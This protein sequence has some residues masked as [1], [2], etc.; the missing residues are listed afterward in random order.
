[1]PLLIIDLTLILT[2]TTVKPVG[3]HW[4]HIKY[5]SQKSLELQY[6]AAHGEMPRQMVKSSIYQFESLLLRQKWTLSPNGDRVLLF[7]PV[8]TSKSS[9]NVYQ[10][11]IVPQGQK[12]P[13]GTIW[14]MIKFLGDRCLH[15]I[16]GRPPL[17]EDFY[18]FFSPYFSM[19]SRYSWLSNS[20]I[21]ITS[22][23]S[24]QNSVVCSSKKEVIFCNATVSFRY[25]SIS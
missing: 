22:L 15:S 7:L 8:H 13:C 9:I 4:H 18:P 23:P 6:L 24:R 1:M 14:F 17:N 5:I 21:S 19:S 20:E 11:K 10:N 25:D 16:G 2:L 12:I 3:T